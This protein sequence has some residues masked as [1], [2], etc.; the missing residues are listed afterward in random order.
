MTLNS[1]LAHFK[2]YKCRKSI[3]QLLTT[4]NTVTVRLQICKNTLPRILTEGRK[5]EGS[6][7]LPQIK[8]LS[9]TDISPEYQTN[10]LKLFYQL[11]HA[12]LAI[13]NDEAQLIAEKILQD[14]RDIPFMLPNFTESNE[15]IKISVCTVC[16]KKGKS[17]QKCTKCAGVF[18]AKCNPHATKCSQ[19]SADNTPN[20]IIYVNRMRKWWPAIIISKKQIPKNCRENAKKVMGLVFV[21]IIGKNLY[22]QVHASNLLTFRIDHVLRNAIL[23][24]NDDGLNRAVEIATAIDDGLRQES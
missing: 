4:I 24:K 17:L 18:H 1:K 11:K 23:S 21:Y 7:L 20:D 3:E 2:E 9:Q 10:V 8:L 19:C 6:G 15:P 14:K 16:F 12:S 5:R 13:S 22:Y